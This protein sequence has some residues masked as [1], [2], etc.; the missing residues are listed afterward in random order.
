MCS[1][2]TSTVDSP[3]LDTA[4]SRARPS[5]TRSDARALTGHLSVC[6]SVPIF[7]QFL[8]QASRDVARYSAEWWRDLGIRLGLAVVLALVATFLLRAW[9]RRCERRA[10]DAADD[11][12]EGPRGQ[13]RLATIAGL[14]SAT[15]QVIIWIMIGFYLLAAFGVPLGP[16]FASAGVVGVALGFGAQTIVRDTLA[17]IFIALE[18]QYDVGDVVDLQT[19]GGSSPAASK[20]CRSG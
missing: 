13:A 6:W 17:G 11:S 19:D 1:T 3:S 9:V 4:G 2:V 16:I 10:R 20:D 14:V 8:A 5:A 12:M 7:A 15:L 18:G